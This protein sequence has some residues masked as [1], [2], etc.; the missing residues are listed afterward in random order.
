MTSWAAP[1]AAA[2]AAT[3]ATPLGL[4]KEF[5]AKA[6]A[7][8]G[9]GA[10]QGPFA[11]IARSLG[12]SGMKD[13]YWT[14]FIG[15]RSGSLGETS[16]LF[17]AVGALI[18]LGLRVIGPLIPL[19][20]LGSTAL[21]SWA[22]GLDPLFALLSGGVAFGAVFMA[23]DYSSSPMTPWG[24]AI[25]GVS[26]G[27]IIVLIRKFG[28]FPEGVTYAILIMNALVPFL[29]RIRARKYGYIPPARGGKAGKEA[30]A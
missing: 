3:Q 18:L 24:K 26:I 1:F 9:S 14:L 16:I 8:G 17:I 13:V 28:A 21:L 29:N 22:L 10:G 11:D 27:A 6:A 30:R 23:T 4:F 25:Y 12:S 5:A 2:D 7:S 20:V 15:N 19:A